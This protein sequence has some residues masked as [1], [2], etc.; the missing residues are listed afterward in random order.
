VTSDSPLPAHA[1]HLADAENW[2]SI[3]RVGL[4]CATALIRQAGLRGAAAKPFSFYRAE[5]PRL[6]S[7]VRLRDQCPMPPPALARCLDAGLTPADWYALVNAHVYFWLDQDRLA[8]HRA[9]CAAR[10]QIIVTLDLPALLARHGPRAFLTP[11]NVGNARRRPA[12]RG[13][14]TFVPLDAWLATRWDSEARPGDKPR[15]RSHAPAE[16]AI[17]GAV[18]DVMDFVI[19]Q[20]AA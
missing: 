3:Q 13:Q 16:L 11:F 19:A 8:R 5:N 7:G 20:A 9:A 17:A 12:A 6:P 2:P 18:P 1:F 15:A 14:R 10:P 4:H